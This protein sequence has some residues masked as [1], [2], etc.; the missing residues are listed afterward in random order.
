MVQFNSEVNGLDLY[1]DARYLCGLNEISDT[2]S[3]PIKAFTRNANFAMERLT[4][5]IQTADANWKYIDANLGN[6]A[7]ELLDTPSFI[8]GTARI[9][10]NDVA[11]MAR[12]R[13]TDQH[14]IYI[15]LPKRDRPKLDDSQLNASP[16]IPASYYLLG[17]FL[18]FDKPTNYA[19]TAEI[20]FQDVNDYFD[21]TDTSKAP[22][23]NSQFHRLV[24]MH[25]A[26]DY[27]RINNMPSRVQQLDI[28]IG[29]PP[30]LENG[31]PGSGLEKELVDFYSQRDGD[32][33]PN[34]SFKQDDYGQSALSNM[35]NNNPYGFF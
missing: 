9:N 8:S 32:E 12:V 13:I 7:A 4:A 28:A 22:G 35:S 14:G 33:Q 5:L 29:S 24:S 26:R 15:T 23:F 6:G 18:Y 20:Q 25:A 10:I 31:E 11:K 34:I 16:G 17:N 2:T 3:Y 19:G 27:C 30:D 1:S 21:Y